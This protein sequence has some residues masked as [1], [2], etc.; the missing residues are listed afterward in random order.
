M[1]L[2][3]QND[4]YRSFIPVGDGFGMELMGEN[5]R[6]EL[7]GFV[8]FN[9]TEGGQNRAAPVVVWNGDPKEFAIFPDCISGD[10][11]L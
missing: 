11:E 6:H 8:I 10:I 1:T 3:M 7:V 5:E 9:P 2:S 4:K